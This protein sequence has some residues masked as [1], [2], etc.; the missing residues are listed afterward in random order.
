ARRRLLRR[1]DQVRPL[2]VAP[3][4]RR[5]VCLGSAA[6]ATGRPSVPGHGSVSIPRRLG[7]PPSG[8][9]PPAPWFGP[10]AARAPRARFT[11]AWA[12]GVGEWDV[13][14]PLGRQV[15]TNSI[16]ALFDGAALAEHWRG[17]GEVEGRSLNAYDAPTGR[18][19]QT[20][21]DSAG[22]LL[23]LDGGMVGDSMVLE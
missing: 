2:A 19:H 9:A 12:G 18:W 3:G 13:F 21:V 22:G 20:W 11:S 23:L 15:G 16:T 6:I 14:G 10:R 1:D 17:V 4:V 7:S 8:P 5:L